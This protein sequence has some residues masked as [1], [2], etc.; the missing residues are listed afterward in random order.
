MFETLT[1]KGISENRLTVEDSSTSTNENFRN[2]LEKLK[3]EGVE[4]TEITIVTNDFHQYRSSL[5]AKKLGLK[6]YSCPSST[7]FMGFVPFAVREVLAVWAMK[8]KMV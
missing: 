5:I 2:S 8:L 6:A 4:I 7:P 3:S 1:R